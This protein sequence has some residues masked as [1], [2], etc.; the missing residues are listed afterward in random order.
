MTGMKLQDWFW[1]A[2]LTTLLLG[3][4]ISTSPVIGMPIHLYAA[5]L[6]AVGLVL[7]VLRVGATPGLLP[8]VGLAA[9]FLPGLASSLTNEYSRD[10]VFNLSATFLA[11]FA[12]IYLL[13]TEARRKAWVGSLLLMSAL[14]VVLA[15]LYPLNSWRFAL[16]GTNYI[17]SGRL[18]ALGLC[19]SGMLLVLRQGPW[20]LIAASTG[21]F[22]FATF[23]TGSR[24]PLFAAVIA[25]LTV[26][27]FRRGQTVNRVIALVSGLAAFGLAVLAV[28]PMDNYLVERFLGTGTDESS[29]SRVALIDRAFEMGVRNPFGVGWGN[30]DPDGIHQ[31]PHNVPVEIFAEG[32]WFAMLAFGLFAVVAFIRLWRG[33]SDPVG[34]LVLGVAIFF[35]VNAFVSADINGNRAMFAALAVAWATDLGKGVTNEEPKPARVEERRRVGASVGGRGSRR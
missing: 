19:V 12:A 25:I 21:L 28:V 26:A 34:A 5:G 14:T 4:F 3:G 8:I 18:V 27:I 32:G 13:R 24:G 2:A 7:A 33:S 6:L 35:T 11:M 31:Y 1:G 22:G 9:S 30:F 17:G 15:Y 29:Q 20:P 16:A 23:L 10:K